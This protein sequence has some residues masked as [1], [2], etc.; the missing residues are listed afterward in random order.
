MLSSARFTAVLVKE[1]IQMRRDRMTFAMMIGLPIVQLLLFGF[2][3]NSNPRHLPT[4]I[5][6]HDSG[7]VT[8]AVVAAMKNSAYFDIIGT[9]PGPEA[10]EEALKNGSAIFIIVRQ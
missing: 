7:Q 2:A 10:S 3:I 8:R 6:L 1:F 9:S 5:E 4:L